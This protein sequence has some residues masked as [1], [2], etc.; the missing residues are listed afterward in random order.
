MA[1]IRPQAGVKVRAQVVTKIKAQ[2]MN[3][4]R[5]QSVAKSRAQM[6]PEFQDWPLARA[7]MLLQSRL[8][9]GGLC[10]SYQGNGFL[11]KRD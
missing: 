11:K 9:D 2:T 6:R 5:F 4:I 8:C 3:R 1:K 7:G 10:T